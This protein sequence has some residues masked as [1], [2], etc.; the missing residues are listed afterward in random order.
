MASMMVE[1]SNVEGKV[2]RKATMLVEGWKL[3]ETILK[4]STNDGEIFDSWSDL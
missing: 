3:E 2:L 4:C 1:C